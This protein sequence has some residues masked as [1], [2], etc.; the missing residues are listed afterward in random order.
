LVVSCEEFFERNAENGCDAAQKQDG[1][2]ALASFELSQVALG[3][4]G[5]L[6]EELPAH[7]AAV[8]EIADAGAQADEKFLARMLC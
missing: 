7:A 6:S 5:F 1:D 2:I 4:F 3:N 8:A